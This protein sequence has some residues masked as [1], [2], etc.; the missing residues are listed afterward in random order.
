MLKIVKI[1][2]TEENMQIIDELY[3]KRGINI[4]DSSDGYAHQSL[5]I[6]NDGKIT[7]LID[8]SN[9]ANVQIWNFH[10][11]E[12]IKIIEVSTSRGLYD[13]F[14]WNNNYLIVG[15]KHGKIIILD[16]I[17][18]VICQKLNFH[19]KDILSIK[20]IIHP[21]FGECLISQGWKNDQ[22]KLWKNNI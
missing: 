10:S 5:I 11:R 7:R 6:N 14:L 8:S 20:K 12:L 3:N 15:G 13:I 19:N 21:Q 4:F 22:I 9:Y 18:G 16:L 1:D 17:K 2:W